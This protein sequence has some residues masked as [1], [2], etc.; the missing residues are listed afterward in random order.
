MAD[1]A[2]TQSGAVKAPAGGKLPARRALRIAQKLCR[3]GWWWAW[4]ILVGRGRGIQGM[5]DFV[6]WD[7]IVRAS[8]VASE[9]AAL[10]QILAD[11]RPE[12]AME[13]GTYA[14]GTLFFLTRLASPDATIISI[15]LPGG[16]FGGG[17]GTLRKWVYQRFARGRQGLH[18]FQGDSH[19]SEMLNRVKEVLGGQPLDYL[20][21]DG[22]HTYEGVRKDF[23]MY[24][25]LVRRGGVIALHD[26]V[27][28]PPETGCEVSRFWN[29]IKT[30]YRHRELIEN[31]NQ[32]WAGIGVIYVDQPADR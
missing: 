18:L 16:R 27:E 31:A 32:G 25:P 4:Y 9:L 14:G 30:Q 10:G 12:R 5:A 28:H 29:E 13:I 26:I 6:A 19:A 8:Q 20:F 3:F 23:E 24:G 7:P 15:D 21:I 22:D 11:L 2:V 1:Q 17:Y